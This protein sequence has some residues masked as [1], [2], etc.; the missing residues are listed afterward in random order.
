MQL[1]AACNDPIRDETRVLTVNAEVHLNGDNHI[2]NVHLGRHIV[3]FVTV[4][5]RYSVKNSLSYFI[6]GHAALCG[7]QQSNLRQN[8]DF[9]GKSRSA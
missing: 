5:R 3:R 4:Y 8:K 6:G 7:L 1:C 2:Q 9:N